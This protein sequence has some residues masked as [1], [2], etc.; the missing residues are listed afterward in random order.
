MNFF[1]RGQGVTGS[2]GLARRRVVTCKVRVVARELISGGEVARRLG[3][4]RQAVRQ[5]RGHRGSPEPVLQVGRAMVWDRAAVEPWAAKV[6]QQPGG[7][8]RSHG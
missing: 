2:R 5:W 1:T 6:R 8:A 7:K 3:V 4:S